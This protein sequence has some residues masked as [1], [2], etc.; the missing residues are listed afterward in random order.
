M[1][2]ELTQCLAQLDQADRQERLLALGRLT[3]LADPAAGSE[4]LR[5]LELELQDNQDWVFLHALI[6][7]LGTL[8]HRPALAVLRQMA[9][10]G[11]PRPELEEALGMSMVQLAHDP[12]SAAQEVLRLL[13]S[14]R[15]ALGQ[16]ALQAMA[17]MQ[18]KPD[19][20]TQEALVSFALG[21]D[22]AQ[23]AWSVIWILRAAPGWGSV[24]RERLLE[25]F[26]KPE[27]EQL[28][29]VHQAAS[30]AANAEYRTWKR[31]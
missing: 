6:G 28:R 16:G 25:R 13:E 18:L 29:Q 2:P 26:L 12:A 8:A 19:Q 21:L 11:S 7:A 30:L 27:Y 22:L 24:A 1:T 23:D 10:S 5:R 15:Q 31:F 17:C 20:D 14:G 3:E 4:L 9:N